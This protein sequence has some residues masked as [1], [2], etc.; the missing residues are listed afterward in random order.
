MTTLE[1]ALASYLAFGQPFVDRHPD[2]VKYG[3]LQTIH[4]DGAVTL[5]LAES[6]REETTGEDGSKTLAIRLKDEK[7]PFEVV[8]YVKSWN[9]CD[10]VETWLDV[11]HDEKGSV[12]LLRADSF[13]SLVNYGNER[14][15]KVMSLTGKWAH[16]ANISEYD[17]ASFEIR[18]SDKAE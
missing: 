12:K 18:S 13:A 5:R 11:R 4:A 15:V 9:D 2:I 6:G 8:R 3:G 17:S 14:T 10:V 16:E 7:Y 1:I